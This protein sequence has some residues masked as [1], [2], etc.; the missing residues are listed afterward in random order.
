MEGILEV[1]NDT[2]AISVGKGVADDEPLD[3]ADRDG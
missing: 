1:S 2:G 3:G